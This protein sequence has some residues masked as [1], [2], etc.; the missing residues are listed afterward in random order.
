MES[1]IRKIMRIGSRSNAVILPS[2]WVRELGLKHGDKVRLFYTGSKILITPIKEDELTRGQ[3]MIEGTDNVASAKLK[4]AFLEG[5]TNVKLKGDYGEAVKLLQALKG[6]IPS[7]VFVTNPESQ[8]H[9]VIFPEVSIDHSSLL[10]KLCE[11]FK[12]VMRSEGDLHDLVMDF[13]YTQL[14]LIRSLKVRLYEEA[15][16]VA[17]AVDI[18]LFS[19]ILGEL[20]SKVI[21]RPGGLDEEIVDAIAVLVDHY[22]AD[23]L[24]RAVK[25]ASNTLVKIDK[26]PSDLQ[27]Y[28]STIAELIFRKCIRDRAC[29]CKHFFPK[30]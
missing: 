30:V 4:A 27:Q 3:I 29:R 18:A 26:I 14:L 2:K 15:I 19:R 16:D 23:D 25:I 5:I 9:T 10:A 8:Y 7:M 1:E 22:C 6:E 17:S 20:M 12:K 11:L 21:E 24:D 13:N 28:V